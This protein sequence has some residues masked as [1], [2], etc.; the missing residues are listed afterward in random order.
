METPNSYNTTML[1]K[2]F[3]KV[4]DNIVVELKEKSSK[5]PKLSVEH[6]LFIHDLYF[7]ARELSILYDVDKSTICKMSHLKP[8]YVSNGTVRYLITDIKEHFVNLNVTK[9]IQN[10]I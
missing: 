2:D 5:K 10:T 6:G 3:E 8:L 9:T 1:K 4:F 7:T